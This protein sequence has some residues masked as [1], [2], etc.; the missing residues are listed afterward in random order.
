MLTATVDDNIV[1]PEGFQAALQTAV[2]PGNHTL[3]VNLVWTTGGITG[4]GWLHTKKYK[5]NIDAS[6]GDLYAVC[7]YPGDILA[8]KRKGKIEDF[9]EQEK[10]NEVVVNPCKNLTN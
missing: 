1:K 8:V 5:L 3:G 7:Y 9:L 6:A 4:P 2:L 10:W